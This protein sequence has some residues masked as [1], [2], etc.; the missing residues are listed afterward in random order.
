LGGNLDGDLAALGRQRLD[1]GQQSGFVDDDG[2]GAEFG[3]QFNGSVRGTQE[4]DTDEE[5]KDSFQRKTCEDASLT[6]NVE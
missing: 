5:G 4:A 1:G 3:H 6:R 2:F